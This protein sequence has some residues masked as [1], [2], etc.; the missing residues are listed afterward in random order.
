MS[1]IIYYD[2]SIL[3]NLTKVRTTDRLEQYERS[4]H[5]KNLLICTLTLF[6]LYVLLPYLIT[7]CVH[8]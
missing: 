8:V 5:M 1:C 2:K 3:S 6:I 4:L 7:V